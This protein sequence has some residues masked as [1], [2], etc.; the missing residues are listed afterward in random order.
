MSLSLE[1]RTLQNGKTYSQNSQLKMSVIAEDT[2]DAPA[3]R[4]SKRAEETVHEVLLY[5][6]EERIKA[7][8]EPFYEQ[9]STLTQ[10]LNQLIQENWA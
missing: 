3:A 6:I 10:L 5:L 4:D 7:N 2:G 1:Q 9:I 8:L